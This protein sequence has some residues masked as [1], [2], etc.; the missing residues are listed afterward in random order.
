M[1]N[2]IMIL[3]VTA[4]SIGFI[5]TLLGPD[6]YLPFIVL[7][8]ARDWSVMKTGLI[9][10]VCGLGHVGSSVLLG[11]LGVALG[12]GISRLEGFE[13]FRGNL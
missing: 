6:H 1:S 8:R 11:L 3:C 13:A 7:A 10:A 4:L 5:H 2:E 9:T 12:V